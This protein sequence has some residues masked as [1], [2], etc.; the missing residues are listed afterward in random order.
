MITNEE[1]KLIVE[2]SGLSRQKFSLKLNRSKGYV[3][4][5]LNRFPNSLP[6][7]SVC[8]VAHHFP[9]TTKSI[10]GVS[11]FKEIKSISKKINF[12][13]HGL[14]A[15][16]ILN[17]KSKKKKM[18]V[19]TVE[20]KEVATSLQDHLYE[21]VPA[22]NY[23]LPEDKLEQAIVDAVCVVFEVKASRSKVA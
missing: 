23:L 17:T 22:L 10:V 18:K 5:Y 14:R 12:D 1:F 13:P 20:M 16:K 11:R 2:R 4:I 9:K 8:L 3:N 6:L 21:T 7:K 15:E 19:S